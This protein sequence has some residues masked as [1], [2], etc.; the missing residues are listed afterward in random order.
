VRLINTVQL[1]ARLSVL[2]VSFAQLVRLVRQFGLKVVHPAHER[3]H[4][5][6]EHLPRVLLLL[7]LGFDA[8]QLVLK[9]RDFSPVLSLHRLH[10]GLVL[11]VQLLLG[12]VGLIAKLLNDGFNFSVP[13]I[14]HVLL[15][16]SLNL[17][18]LVLDLFQHKRSHFFALDLSLI[19]E[20]LELF[21]VFAAF[22]QQLPF[23]L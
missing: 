14:D 10:F 13:L 4:V 8:V 21:F 5:F 9:V 12:G 23:H 17:D 22:S 18:V 3:L 1:I 11:L 20:H 15:H 6:V 7:V 2:P 19:F 16:L